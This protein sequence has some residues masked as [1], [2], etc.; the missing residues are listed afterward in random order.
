MYLDGAVRLYVGARSKGGAR[1]RRL[2]EG[3]G[4]EIIHARSHRNMP[5]AMYAHAYFAGLDEI[6]TL[7]AALQRCQTHFAQ[8]EAQTEAIIAARR[9]HDEAHRA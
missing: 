3:T 9:V 4:V 6:Q 8:I 2:L 1:A 5:V 7:A